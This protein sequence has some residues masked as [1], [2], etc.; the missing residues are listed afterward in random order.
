VPKTVSAPLCYTKGAKLTE[1][2]ASEIIDILS[3]PLVAKKSFSS[4][5][6]GVFLINTKEELIDFINQNPFEPKIY[7]EFISSSFGRDVRIICIGKKYYSAIERY[8]GS[9]FRSNSA[10]GGNARKIDPPKEFIE[11]AEKVANLLNLDYMGIDLLYG[12]ANEPIV[13]EVNSN[14]FFSAMDKVANVSVA[15]EYAKYLIKAVEKQ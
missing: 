12:K 14:A 11:V 2:S 7:Q 15:K 4:L 10:L 5:G 6:K 8:S 9:D 3:L 1:D 13:C